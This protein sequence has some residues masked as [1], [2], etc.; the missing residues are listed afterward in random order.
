MKPPPH[1]S[2]AS[3]KLWRKI[4]TDY[5]IDLAAEVILEMTLQA[6]DRREQARA[7]IQKHGTTQS[8][9]FGFVKPRPE[10]AIE[11]DASTTAMRGWRLLG[12]DQQPSGEGLH[13]KN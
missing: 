10:V 3:K 7:A 4:C 9:R 12:F 6:C 13:A 8:D 1:L 5:E 2:A 11:R